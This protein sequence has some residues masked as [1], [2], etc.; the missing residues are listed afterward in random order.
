MG[1]VRC[2]V[3]L[4]Q[5]R[6]AEVVRGLATPMEGAISTVSDLTAIGGLRS[7]GNSARAA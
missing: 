5:G 3:G 1:G 4:G 7:L 6:W 2:V